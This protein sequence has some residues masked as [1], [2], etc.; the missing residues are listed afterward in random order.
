M[1]TKALGLAVVIILSL[2]SCDSNS[3]STDNNETEY[4]NTTVPEITGSN[5]M[6]STSDLEKLKEKFPEYF[7]ISDFKGVEVYVW[8]LAENCYRCGL[9]SGTNRGKTSGEI[10]ALQSKSLSIDEAKAILNEL[11]VKK[12]NIIT[13]PISQPYS[14][15]L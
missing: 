1:K 10:M 7:E 8:Q 6:Q 15:Y 11:G 3:I 2:S 12:E 5:E 9:M 13:I 4:T 14:S